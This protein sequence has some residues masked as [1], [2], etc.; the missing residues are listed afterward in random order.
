MATASLFYQGQDAL[1]GKGAKLLDKTGSTALNLEI[2]S[3]ALFLSNKKL[4]F[5]L[6]HFLLF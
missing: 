6:N 5:F 1:E 2:A 3:A 4:K